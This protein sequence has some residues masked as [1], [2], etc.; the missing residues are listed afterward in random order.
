MNELRV[1]SRKRD[2][3]KQSVQVVVEEKGE[4]VVVEKRRPLRSMVCFVGGEAFFPFFP[5]Y[6]PSSH[7]SRSLRMFIHGPPVAGPA[8][9]QT[10]TTPT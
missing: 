6:L 7:I 8:F 2:E 4:Y 9:L 10:K 5:F 1:E 3:V